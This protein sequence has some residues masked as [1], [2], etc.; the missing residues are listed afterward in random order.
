MDFHQALEQHMQAM[1]QKDMESFTATIHQKDITYS[2]EREAY[3]KSERI[4]PV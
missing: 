1:K 4:H 3:S 2:A